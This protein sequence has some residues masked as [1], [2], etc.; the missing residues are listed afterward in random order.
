M[1][2]LRSFVIFCGSLVALPA[3][4]GVVVAAPLT[5]VDQQLLISVA[6][7][8][9]D[10][11]NPQAAAVEGFDQPFKRASAGT[12]WAWPPLV[13]IS[14]DDESNAFATICYVQPGDT[15][16]LDDEPGLVWLD[17]PGHR[18][19]LADS[20]KAVFELPRFH[21]QPDGSVVQPVIVFKQGYM[22]QIVR[23]QE[24]PLAGTFGH[25]LAHVLLGHVLRTQTSAPLVD[26][27]VTRQ[28]EADADELGAIVAERAKF[29]YDAIVAGA[30]LE[31]EYGYRCSF[32]GMRS[33]H[34]GWNDRLALID[35]RK[36]ELW[37]SVDAFENGVYFLMV[38]QYPLAVRC[39]DEVT[40]KYPQCYEA[41]ANKGYAELMI[42]C[43]ALEPD[44]L[45]QFDIGHLVVGGF[46]A[47]PESLTRGI[48]EEMW[49][50]AVGDLRQAI[51]LK[52]D[53][54]MAKANLAVAWLVRPA[55]KEAGRAEQLFQEVSDALKEGHFDEPIDPLVHASLLINA[56]VAEIANGDPDAAET[57]FEEA[58]GLIASS[59][60]AD[61]GGALGSAIRFNRARMLAAQ[62][63]AAQ[64]GA[65]VEEF[66]AYLVASSP[67]STWWTVAF[68][69]YQAL[70]RDVGKEAKA[71]HDLASTQ[72]TQFRMATGI[73][74]SGGQ[75][76]TLNDAIQVIDETLGPGHQ[77]T[78]IENTKV[79][80]R[81]YVD[82]GLDLL[83]TD[84]VVAIR[85]QGD[86]APPL[87]LRATGQS[88]QSQALRPG[89]AL[90]EVE[91]ML[92]ADAK[93][94]DLRY[95][96]SSSI[97]YRFYHRLGFGVRLNDDGRITEIIVAQIPQAASVR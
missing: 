5:E 58:R 59:N 37:R 74:L 76:I 31:R 34:P 78:V 69:E 82:L 84:R 33:S 16:Q 49:F 9:F 4:S 13:G 83:C 15:P 47:R 55:G 70:C 64:R 72:R 86:K 75:S 21:D 46:Y 45:R 95:G 38:E 28:Q 27:A 80:R 19:R 2:S 18:A 20:D 7:R 54:V 61:R 62:T 22:D 8:F 90:A 89:M 68:D 79:H 51:L 35:S 87:V 10:E 1:N 23:G 43:D 56:G 24:G 6:A 53:L 52:P 30:R 12:N 67:A 92:G 71:Q 26:F 11:V 41:W 50:D 29:D 3:L 44:D 57:M 65:A 77:Q 96:T 85:L 88:Q 81:R 73:E 14:T 63:D 66:E 25:E 60:D 17:V 40:K 32:L 36:R 94:W 97:V 93:N 42:F 48:D 91:T 39:F